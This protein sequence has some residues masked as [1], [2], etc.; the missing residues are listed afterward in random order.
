MHWCRGGEG[1]GLVTK[2]VLV[3]GQTVEKSKSWGLKCFR[4]R[5]YYK[6]N[7]LVVHE[8]HEIGAAWRGGKGWVGSGG[9]MILE[10]CF[11]EGRLGERGGVMGRGGGRNRRGRRRRRN[12]SEEEERRQS[13][14][15][16][17]N[18]RRRRKR[19]DVSSWR[20]TAGGGWDGQND[21]SC[22]AAGCEIGRIGGK[23]KVE[24]TVWSGWA[25]VMIVQKSEMETS[26]SASSIPPCPPSSPKT[27]YCLDYFFSPTLL[28]AF[29]FMS[30]LS[31][32]EKDFY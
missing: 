18:R 27:K 22:T 4:R 9:E 6:H 3:S 19:Q 28:L 13:R 21:Y 24:A 1:C 25:W 12:M 14:R 30:N 29:P 7:C 20:Q 11:W 16:R 32:V 31:N 23:G 15:R 17:I 26:S 8:S 2:S 10:Q 5:Y